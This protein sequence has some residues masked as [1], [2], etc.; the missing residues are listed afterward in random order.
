MKTGYGKYLM[1]MVE[2]GEVHEYNNK[3][4]TNLEV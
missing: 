3:C 4:I 1:D 2:E